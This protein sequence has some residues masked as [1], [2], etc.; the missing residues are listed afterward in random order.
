M[1]L[2]KKLNFFHFL[3]W[4]KN[5]LEKMFGDLLDRKESKICTSDSRIFAYFRKGLTHD[6]SQ[7][8]EVFHF[9]FWGKNDLEK[10]F[11]DL[12]HK[13]NRF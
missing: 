5:Y 13:K 8:I 7:K 12:L 11:G 4:G 1:I 3:F 10:M 9:L 6:F 2:V